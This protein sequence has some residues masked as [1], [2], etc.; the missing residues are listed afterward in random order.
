MLARWLVRHWLADAPTWR[1]HV[2]LRAA[3]A[4]DPLAV[5]SAAELAAGGWLVADAREPEDTRA[6]QLQCQRWRAALLLVDAGPVVRAPADFVA[7]SG[8][9]ISPR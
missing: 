7:R 6:L 8:R 1:P 2:A 3:H 4:G 9:S 5:A